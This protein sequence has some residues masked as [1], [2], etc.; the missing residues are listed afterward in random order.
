MSMQMFQIELINLR[1]KT[2]LVP[3]FNSETQPLFTSWAGFV[4]GLTVGSIYEGKLDYEAGLV[5]LT[6]L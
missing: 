1:S 5:K 3:P 6:L 2:L 4:G